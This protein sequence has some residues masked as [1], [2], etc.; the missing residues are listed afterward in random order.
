MRS[1]NGLNCQIYWSGV[2]KRGHVQG[3]FRDKHE[4]VAI[5]IEVG[6]NPPNPGAHCW[7]TFGREK[8][9]ARNLAMAKTLAEL[10]LLKPQISKRHDLG[11]VLAELTVLLNSAPQ[12]LER[13]AA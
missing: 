7:L 4:D 13:R 10:M 2:D 8:I 5:L 9:E 1:A 11:Q 12:N 6:G 3:R